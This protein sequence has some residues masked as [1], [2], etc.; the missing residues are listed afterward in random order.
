MRLYRS[1]HRV[2]ECMQRRATKMTGE[3]RACL[4]KRD[5]R[6]RGD[7]LGLCDQGD[8]QGGRKLLKDKEQ[9]AIN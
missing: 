9:V 6:Q 7:M 1:G 8:K 2:Q 3:R 4:L 5:S